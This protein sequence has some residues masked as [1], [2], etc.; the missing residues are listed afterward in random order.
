MFCNNAV[1]HG[2]ASR[3][4]VTTSAAFDSD[5]GPRL[6]PSTPTVPRLWLPNKTVS[7]HVWQQMEEGF[8]ALV[9]LEWS[10]LSA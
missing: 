9:S 7:V 3:T 10:R 1:H 2:I 6:C 8:A 5:V 4:H